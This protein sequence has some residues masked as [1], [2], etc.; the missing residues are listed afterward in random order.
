MCIAHF[1]HG[2]RSVETTQ[3]LR[4]HQRIVPLVDTNTHQHSKAGNQNCDAAPPTRTAACH[5]VL[6]CETGVVHAHCCA[7]HRTRC[8]TVHTRV[9][10]TR[11]RP[12][13]AC[14]LPL[15]R[16]VAASYRQLHYCAAHW[17]RG[18]RMCDTRARR[19]RVGADTIH[20]CDTYCIDHCCFLP[21]LLLLH[22]L[23]KQKL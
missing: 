14:L 16:S 1:W 15:Q 12:L 9:R 6:V 21:Y 10:G 13:S 5:F 8:S 7:R 3:P 11:T 4:A 18:H 2:G 19:A 22:A 23:Q 20:A 17:V